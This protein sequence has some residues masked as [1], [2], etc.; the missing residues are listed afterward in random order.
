MQAISTTSLEAAARAVKLARRG[1]P[2]EFDEGPLGDI[3]RDELVDGLP[4]WLGTRRGWLYLARNDAWPGLYKVGC[5]R[6]SVEQRLHDLS[7]TGVPTP[8][9]RVRSWGAYDAYGLEARAH[10]ACA[11]WRYQGELFMADP[12]LIAGAV[13]HAI[14]AD[15]ELLLR[16]LSSIFVPGRLDVLLD[17]AAGMVGQD[18]VEFSYT[19]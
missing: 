1:Q 11:D 18:H 4:L 14:E 2:P 19:S 15:R 17:A 3:E 16:H 6:K 10:A 12:R 7:G 9:V 13:V 8:W 5:T